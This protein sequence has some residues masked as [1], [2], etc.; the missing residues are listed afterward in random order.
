MS[1]VHQFWCRLLRIPST[2]GMLSNIML[3]PN[4]G[5]RF[6]NCTTRFNK[7]HNYQSSRP[8]NYSFS[9]FSKTVFENEEYLQFILV[10]GGVLTAEFDRLGSQGRLY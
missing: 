7:S 5:T 2:G 10:C 9:F 3:S 6:S 4:L 1:G 8:L